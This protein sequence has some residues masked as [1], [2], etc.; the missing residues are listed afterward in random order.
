MKDAPNSIFRGV[1]VTRISPELLVAYIIA[2]SNLADTQQADP[3][4]CPQTGVCPPFSND[5]DFSKF[6]N[7]DNG[8]EIFAEYLLCAAVWL[9]LWSSL[10]FLPS[11]VDLLHSTEAALVKVTGGCSIANPSGHCSANLT[12]PISSLD[13]IIDHCLLFERFSSTNL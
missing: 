12:Q 5:L 8:L 7:I 1:S 2:L 9:Y 10:S 13:L 11:P 3:H 4:R 6:H